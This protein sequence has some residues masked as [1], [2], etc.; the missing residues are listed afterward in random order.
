MQTF[1]WFM[2]GTHAPCQIAQSGWSTDLGKIKAYNAVVVLHVTRD[3]RD[4]VG[5]RLDWFP[6]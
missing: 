5:C 1:S 4:F 2:V 6:E 3:C